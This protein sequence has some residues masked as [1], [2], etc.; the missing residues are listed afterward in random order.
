MEKQADYGGNP[1]R[2]RVITH[3]GRNLPKASASMIERCKEIELKQ[4]KLEQLSREIRKIEE[5]IKEQEIQFFKLARF[6]YSLEDIKMAKAGEVIN[7]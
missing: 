6:R 7:D 2:R 3:Y 1:Q 4:E 5:E